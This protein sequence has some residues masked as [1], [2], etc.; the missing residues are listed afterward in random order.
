MKPTLILL[1]FAVHSAYSQQGDYT[2]GARS[3]GMGSANTALP[4]YFSSFNNIGGLAST[5]RSSILFTIKNLYA[6]D[7][8]NSLGAAYNHKFAKSAFAFS[9]YRFG[10]QL[11]NEHKIGLGYSHKIGFVSLGA[12][13]NYLQYSVKSYGTV[14]A[15]V[16]EFGGMANIFPKILVGAYIFNPSLTKIGN[17]Q[18]E[19]LP[20]IIKAAI[21]YQ[22]DTKTTLTIEARQKINF[23]TGIKIGLEYIFKEKFPLRTGII[24]RPPRFSC[25]FGIHL[26]KFQMDY[27][28]SIDPHLGMSNQLSIAY[29]LK[30]K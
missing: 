25:G 6:V 4:D 8:L 30:I 19:P 28:T 9:L 17:E 18:K 10:D 7:G 22:P 21:A 20:I 2:L 24:L 23:T 27:A 11:L 13:I 16:I 29:L 26:R 1:V 12:Q 15:F 3:F 14:G 5:D